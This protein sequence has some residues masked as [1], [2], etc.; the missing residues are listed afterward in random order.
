MSGH[1]CSMPASHFVGGETQDWFSVKRLLVNVTSALMWVDW[2]LIS[3]RETEVDIN[4]T[5]SFLNTCQLGDCVCAHTCV[6]VC[7]Q[8]FMCVSLNHSSGMLNVTWL[9]SMTLA[10]IGIISF[11]IRAW[12]YEA[13]F[14]H[15]LVATTVAN[16]WMENKQAHT[17]QH[18]EKEVHTWTRQ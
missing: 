12:G 13:T 9:H 4:N 7:V 5:L 6:S 11:I 15:Q 10:E 2:F 3:I 17:P 18:I 8:T 1:L 16:T 14:K